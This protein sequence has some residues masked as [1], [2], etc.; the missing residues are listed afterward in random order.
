MATIG[1]SYFGNS[2]GQFFF[3]SGTN[4]NSGPLLQM[5]ACGVF[6]AL[7]TAKPNFSLWRS[8]HM[9]YSNFAMQSVVQPFDSG[10]A[11]FGSTASC[12]L[13]KSG[14]LVYFTY[15][16]L[17]LPGIRA[18]PPKAGGCGL[19]QQYPYAIDPANPCGVQD[20]LYFSTLDG[21]AAQWAYDCYASCSDFET[22]CAANP[23]GTGA[24]VC[25]AEPFAYWT[26]AIGFVIPR[27]TSLMIGSQLIDT[28]TS[29]YLFMWEE[30]A[31]T[32]GKRLTEMVGKRFCV[33][34]LIADS[35]QQRTLYVPL[36]FYYTQ[37]PGNALPIVSLMFSYA[38]ICVQFEQ[39]TNCII[40]SGPGVRVVNCGTGNDLVAGDLKAAIETLQIFL[41]LLERDSFASTWF[42]QLI[43]QVYPLYTDVCCGT[44]R[45]PLY[46]THPIV[47]IIWAVRRQCQSEH[48]NW[49]NYSGIANKEP[50]LAAGLLFNGTERQQMRDANWYR[51]VQPYQ[52]H[53]LIPDAPVYDYSFALYPEESQ[54]TGC[55]NAPRLESITLVLLFQC[56]LEKEDLKVI[57][58][59]RCLNMLKFRDGCGGVVFS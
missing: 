36:P 6:T 30:L 37:T 50:L 35:S 10:S 11:I 5:S 20:A 39:L 2:Q 48:N 7:L 32:P 15:L 14:D 53:S 22:D 25:D 49:F 59:M 58:Q 52:F 1:G 3:G 51:L 42:E 12:K 16:V 54:P 41:D 27:Q 24:A 57:V 45:I 18:C 31:G 23:C 17:G 56:G 19:V 21:G 26:N 46:V 9:Q 33:E 29:D 13:Q 55:V 34:E 40:V 38:Q 47:E 8:R 4:S 28:I 44:A 43:T